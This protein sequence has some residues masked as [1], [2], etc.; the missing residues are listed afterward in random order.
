M[1]SITLTFNV[2]LNVSLQ[3]G[4]V[5]FYKDLT[6]DKVYLIGA[7]TDIT[8]SVVTCDIGPS[9]PRPADGDFIFF[10]KNSEINMSGV[11]GY[12][13]SVKMDL[14]GAAKKE[15]FAVSAEIFHSS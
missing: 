15:L 12:F 7:V 8:G 13:A 6:D 10:A 4:D 2:T 9:T 14:S 3:V 1:D 5:T 11:V